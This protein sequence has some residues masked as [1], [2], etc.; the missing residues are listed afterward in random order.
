[1]VAINSM[2]TTQASKLQIRARRVRFRPWP[3][4]FRA[5]GASVGKP[6]QISRRLPAEALVKAGFHALQSGQALL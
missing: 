5:K 2:K 3:S 6:A 1:M 4:T